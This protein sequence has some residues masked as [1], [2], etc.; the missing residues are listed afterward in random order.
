MPARDTQ[1][2]RFHHNGKTSLQCYLLLFAVLLL[3]CLYVFAVRFTYPP[4]VAQRDSWLVTRLPPRPSTLRHTSVLH[5][6]AN[7]VWNIES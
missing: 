5:T 2:H 4:G 7:I 1:C 3:L 6:P